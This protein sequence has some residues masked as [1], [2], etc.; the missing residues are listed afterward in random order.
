[1]NHKLEFKVEGKTFYTENQY[2]TGKE[3]KDLMEIPLSTE[4]FLAIVE[5]FEHELILNDTRVNL[6]RP[7]I[8][9]FFVKKK[10]E[11]S[12]NGKDFVSYKQFI[13]G[14]ELRK[15]GGI[16]DN[17]LV[18]LDNPD[19]WVDDLIEDHELVDLAR[20][21][22][23]KFVSREKEKTFIVVNGT[24][25]YWE[26]DTISFNEV[27]ALSGHVMTNPNTAFTVAYENGC[28]SRPEGIL[29]SGKSVKVKNKM[30]FYVT[31]TDKS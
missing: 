23:E 7:D 29:T 24:S 2:I 8:E 31:A 11:Y 26:K 16:P 14:L 6:A 17:Q 9:Q 5:P 25:H 27:I 12:I 15:V 22:K 3:L 30:I 1:M 21:G 20:E 10:L 19:G 4:L 13:T 28:H 18:Y